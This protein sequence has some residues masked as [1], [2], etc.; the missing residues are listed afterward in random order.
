MADSSAEPFWMTAIFGARAGFARSNRTVY[1]R[2]I[3]AFDELRDGSVVVVGT[4]VVV[5][6]GAPDEL[7]AA[8]PRAMR[9]TMS[10]AAAR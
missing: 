9:A 6:G 1:T 3:E 10:I 8:N 5:V 7:H 2:S 4:V